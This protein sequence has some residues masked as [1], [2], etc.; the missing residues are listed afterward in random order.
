MKNRDAVKTKNRDTI[1]TESVA[2]AAECTG[3]MPS[4]PENRQQAD[5]EAELYGVHPPCK[6]GKKAKR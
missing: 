4:L 1:E 3:L 6:S 2:S 5:S